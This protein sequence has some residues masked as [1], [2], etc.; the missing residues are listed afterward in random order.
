MFASANL[1]E[2]WSQGISAVMCF[3]RNSQ[4]DNLP[5]STNVLRKNLSI[6]TVCIA[7]TEAVKKLLD[8]DVVKVLVLTGSIQYT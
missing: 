5:A 7:S 1:V 8:P 6:G 3:E 2:L 4:A